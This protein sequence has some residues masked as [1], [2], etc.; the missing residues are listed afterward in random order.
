VRAGFST[1][2][3]DDLTVIN[4]RGARA[5]EFDYSRGESSPEYVPDAVTSIVGGGIYRH[6]HLSEFGKAASCFGEVVN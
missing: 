5:R 4:D 2:V 1:I 3:D 6:L